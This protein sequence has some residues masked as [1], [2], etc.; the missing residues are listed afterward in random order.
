MVGRCISYWNSPFLGDMLVFEGVHPPAK[1]N[2]TSVNFGW[3]CT[4]EWHHPPFSD[5]GWPE[6]TRFVERCAR[7]FPNLP[8][9]A[10]GIL[11]GGLWV[12]VGVCF[13]LLPLFFF[14]RW[15]SAVGLVETWRCF[16]LFRRFHGMFCV[17]CFERGSS[18]GCIS[19]D[20]HDDHDDDDDDDE[21]EDERSCM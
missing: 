13:F 7:T 5:W 15:I 11:P 21:D 12:D 6:V 20:D 10:F 4:T 14:R 8:Q 1:S 17:I 16:V 19:G 9:C 2:L 18:Q 3:I